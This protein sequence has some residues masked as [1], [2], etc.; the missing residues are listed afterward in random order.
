MLVVQHPAWDHGPRSAVR[1]PRGLEPKPT[2]CMIIQRRRRS[3]PS[4]VRLWPP[5]GCGRAPRWP[6]SPERGCSQCSLKSG[7]LRREF[8]SRRPDRR[9]PNDGHSTSPLSPLLLW[10]DER[11]MRSRCVL[12]AATVVAT[13]AVT[14]NLVVAQI[15]KEW[16]QCSGG[17]GPIADI[18]ISGCSAVIQ[19]SQDSP[20]RLATAF[21]NRGVAYKFKG[22][23]DHALEDYDR[24][25]HLNPSF[26]NAYNR[27]LDL[28]HC[29][30]AQ[31]SRQREKS[32]QVRDLKECCSGDT[33]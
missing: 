3:P 15:S 31:R 4:R 8:C 27:V 32:R 14:S 16:R 6:R 13:V 23:Y 10:S 20:K 7:R 28:P 21:N 17:E 5:S 19:A 29:D 12:A 33:Q 1:G 25:I 18:V 26:A 24:A 2:K 30:A 9:S 11:D 22:E